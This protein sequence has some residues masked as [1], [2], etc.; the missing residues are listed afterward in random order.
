LALGIK[1]A[2]RLSLLSDPQAITSAIDLEVSR[3]LEELSHDGS[4]IGVDEIRKMFLA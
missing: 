3:A 1:L 4:E 2:P